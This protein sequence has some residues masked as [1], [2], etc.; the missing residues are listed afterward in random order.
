[1][2]RVLFFGTSS[3]AVPALETLA[4]DPRFSIVGVIT[5][6]DRPSGRHAVL[7]PSPVKECALHL[8]TPLFQFERIKSEEAFE[9]LRVIDADVGVVASFGQ[10]IPDRI[11]SIPHHSCL[12]IHGSLLPKYRGASPVAG[13]ILAGDTET[14]ITIILMD[15]LMDHGPILS[16]AKEPIHPEDTTKSLLERLA[17]LGATTLPSVITAYTEG[18]LRPIPQAHEQAT[19][20]SLLTRESGHVTQAMSASTIER[21]IRAYTPWPGVYTLM[22]GKRVKLLRARVTNAPSSE[23]LVVACVDKTFL[24]ILDVQPE[25]KSPMSGKAFLHGYGPL[26]LEHSP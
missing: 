8:A 21:M 22:N 19:V 24:H 14:G 6:P 25:G 2:I 13:S 5:Q 23:H 3:F 11:L 12:N 9:A 17:L 15:A 7:T 18:S 4:H 26:S 1:M 16:T 20:V 10:I